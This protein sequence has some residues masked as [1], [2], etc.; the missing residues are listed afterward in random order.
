M[1]ATFAAANVICVRNSLIT[2]HE[3]REMDWNV[4]I[5]RM[6]WSSCV[7]GPI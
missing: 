3:H 4:R 7:L 6:G 1:I 5:Y 2:V